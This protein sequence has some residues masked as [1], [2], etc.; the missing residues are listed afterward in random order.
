MLGS[1]LVPE[2]EK[3]GYKKQMSLGPILG[4]GGLAIMIP[5]SA[6]AVFIGAVAEASI[7]RLL[8]AI[9]FP[10]LLMIMTAAYVAGFALR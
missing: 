2:I 1:T 9:I 4:S 6:I 5:P 10:G 8:V 7:G 3:R